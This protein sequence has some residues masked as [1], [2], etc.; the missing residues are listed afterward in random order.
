M[1]PSM[2]C[3]AGKGYSDLVFGDNWHG[4]RDVHVNC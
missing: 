1:G 2:A 4:V 3:L